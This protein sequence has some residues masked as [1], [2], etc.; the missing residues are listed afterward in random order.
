MARNSNIFFALWV[1]AIVLLVLSVWRC[2]GLLVPDLGNTKKSCQPGEVFD[3][4]SGF[5][6]PGCGENKCGVKAAGGP[7]T[8]ECVQGCWCKGK[9]YR[10]KRDKKCVPK[11]ECLK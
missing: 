9:M 10:R 11:N 4:V 2:E 3:C 6:E 7:C 5:P 8:K 1:P